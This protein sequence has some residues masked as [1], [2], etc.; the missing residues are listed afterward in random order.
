[1]LANLRSMWTNYAALEGDHILILS[2]T[3]MVMEHTDIKGVVGEVS[4]KDVELVAFILTASDGVVETRLKQREIGTDLES[5]L[6]STEMRGKV[7]DDFDEIPVWRIS[8]DER[9]VEEIAEEVIEV[10][11]RTME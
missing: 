2:G 4:G 3:S 8:T 7:L 5:H 9:K 6:R 1:M 11:R 10:M